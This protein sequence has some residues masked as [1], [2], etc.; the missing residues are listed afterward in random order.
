MNIHI[1]KNYRRMLKLANTMNSYNFREF[2]KR[3]ILGDFRSGHNFSQNELELKYE[4]LKR[5]I[6]VQNLYSTYTTGL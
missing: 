4:E 5:I 2:F 6:T 3:K 1:L